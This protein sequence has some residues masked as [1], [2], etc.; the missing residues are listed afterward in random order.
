MLG[1]A[2]FPWCVAL[3][4]ANAHLWLGEMHVGICFGSFWFLFAVLV[5]C[6]FSQACTFDNALAEMVNNHC[7]CTGGGLHA[8]LFLHISFHIWTVPQCID[9]QTRG[10]KRD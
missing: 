6:L 10:K 8:S 9:G 5:G 4:E 7:T 3:Y 1:P 2:P